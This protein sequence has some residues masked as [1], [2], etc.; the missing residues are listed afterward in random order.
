V[1][2][3]RLTLSALGGPQTFNGQAAELLFERYPMFEAIVYCPTSEAVMEAAL[4]G[5]ADAACGQ[6]QTSRN[7]FHAGMQARIAAPDSP[8][9]VI[10]EATQRY[11]CSLL[12]KPGCELEQVRRI[13]GH[14]GSIAHSRPW[15]ERN[16]PQAKIDTID[17]NSLG[18]ASAVLAGDGSIASVGSAALAREF[19]LA[20]L[21]R[22]IDDG[23]VVNYWAVSL[24]PVFSPTPTR[25][26]VAGRFGDESGMSGLV[27]ALAHKGYTLQAVYPRATGT[28]LFEYDYVL[29]FR[30]TGSLQ[31]VRA[32]LAPMRSARLAGAWEAR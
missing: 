13:V 12:G 31:D 5:K 6:E 8:L 10:A 25:L 2:T 28:A 27:L 32:L 20:E 15:L 26:V 14:A 29:R 19:G 30:G 24:R 4:L 22:E 17:T 9:Y 7:G 11:H 1:S 16:L 3:T 23:S 18:A 21:V